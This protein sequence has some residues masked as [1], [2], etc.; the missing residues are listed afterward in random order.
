LSDFSGLVCNNGN[1]VLSLFPSPD[2]T[3]MRHLRPLPPIEDPSQKWSPVS[4]TAIFSADPKGLSEIKPYLESFFQVDDYRHAPVHIVLCVGSISP[5]GPYTT[6]RRAERS[7]DLLDE[8]API[9]SEVP[10]PPLSEIKE[11]YETLKTQKENG[12]LEGSDEKARW[13]L[14]KM[15]DDIFRIEAQLEDLEESQ[16]HLWGNKYFSVLPEHVTP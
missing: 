14:Q 3:F 13:Y 4:G 2:S 1:A 7:I 15:E 6:V 9:G 12:E 11:R 16:K 10:D 8:W 5:D